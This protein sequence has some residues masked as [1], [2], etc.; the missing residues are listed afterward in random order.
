MIDQF[1]KL[2]A[3]IALLALGAEA[4]AQGT[5][6]V[7]GRC[8]LQPQTAQ[9]G[10]LGNVHTF[11]DGKVGVWNGSAYVIQPQAAAAP[12]AA[13]KSVDGA[14]VVG[15]GIGNLR[16][17][18]ILDSMRSAAEWRLVRDGIKRPDG[19]VVKVTRSQA[20]ELVSRISDDTIFGGAKSLG[21]P[22][23]G[24]FQ[25]FLKWMWDHKEEIVKF[26]LS[27]IALFGDE[28][29]VSFDVLPAGGAFVIVAHTPSG[30]TLF[31][32]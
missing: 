32:G 7:N 22:V 30:P 24:A 21:A 1:T 8:F 17:A 10:P 27:I 18:I 13:P 5:V 16:R 11:S 9:A 25:D 26:I 12:V 20:K 2:V 14:E 23:G 19:K 29:P 6:C 3:A 31:A 15:F 28:V 4:S